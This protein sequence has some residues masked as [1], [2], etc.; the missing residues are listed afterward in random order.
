MATDTLV[1]AQSL[2]R[3]GRWAIAASAFE[4]LKDSTDA[5]AAFEGLGQALWW[6]D[7]GDGCL[8]ARE[9][10]Y[11][12]YRATRDA[13]GAARAATALAWDAVLFGQGA[14]IARGWFGLAADL[15]APFPAS[16]ESGW[17]S[18]REAEIA[19][20]VDHDAERAFHAAETARRLGDALADPDLS[21]AG[22]A[23]SGLALVALGQ[24][25]DGLT[26]LDSAVAAAT[27]GDVG[28]LMWLGKICCW[29]IVACRETHDIERA[30][31]WCERVE[32]LATELGL[33]PL[34][35]EC[36][37][38]HAAVQISRGT[39]ATADEQLTALVE[40]LASSRRE[41]RFEALAEL[42]E[43]RRRQGRTAEANELLDQAEFQTTAIVGRTRLRL[44]R[45][46]TAAAWSLIGGL[47]D[48][49]PR[50]NRLARA[51]V[52]P[53]AVSTAVAIGRMDAAEGFA[54]ELSATAALVG[55]H[56]LLA[57][58]AAARAE[59]GGS[60]AIADGQEAVERFTLVGLQYE[61]AQSRIVLAERLRDAGDGTGAGEQLRAALLAFEHLG[62]TADVDGV[63]LRLADEVGAPALTRRQREVLRLVAAGRTNSE[64]AAEL[65]LS[66]H[67]VHRHVANILDK[68]GLGSRASAAAYAVAHHLI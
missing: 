30:A 5:T 22:A 49:I 44:A 45:G 32:R 42:G 27:A 6:L 34:T 64:I 40:R 28:D 19:F 29:L 55:T 39:W 48:R 26:R 18:V 7:D 23:Y 53:T 50:A 24:I 66:E 1:D 9:R 57:F 68:L 38:Q 17:L 3:S 41:S 31:A 60:A 16:T 10:A 47:L 61:A 35:S 58:A 25:A 59:V 11:R 62:A 67:T 63:R 54:A 8:A 15:L 46:E 14:A 13:R 43:L 36:R 56:P 4:R 20:N 33:S 12:G 2:L 21:F 51:G 52:L 37:I 65:V